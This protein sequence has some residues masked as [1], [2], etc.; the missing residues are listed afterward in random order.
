MQNWKNEDD[1]RLTIKMHLLNGKYSDKNGSFIDL[2]ILNLY[3]WIAIKSNESNVITCF[4]ISKLETKNYTE[5]N[6]ECLDS[7]ISNLFYLKNDHEYQHYV[8][9]RNFLRE[10]KKL[11]LKYYHVGIYYSVS[12]K[13]DFKLINKI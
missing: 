3:D 10:S 13:F 1:C 9:I 6:Q 7:K 2:N 12:G 11:N 4:Y 8:R 5:A